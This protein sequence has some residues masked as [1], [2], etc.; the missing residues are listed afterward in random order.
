MEISFRTPRGFLAGKERE[1]TYFAYS[2]TLRIFGD[3]PD[4]DEISA[5]LGLQP[6]HSHR[7]G[8]KRNPRAAPYSQDMWSY[9]PPVDESEP[10]H[11]HIDTLWLKLKPH[12]RYL[13]RLKKSV[14]VDVFLGYR[15]NCDT[16]G[17]EVP[18]TSLEMFS[19]LRIP[20]GVS[21]IIT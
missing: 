20:F 9:R 1:D 13:L 16:A 2:A 19:E 10:L 11:K 15:S 7:K 18:H 3:I 4:M 6:K 21:I 8:E 17:I 5:R 14:N 12:K